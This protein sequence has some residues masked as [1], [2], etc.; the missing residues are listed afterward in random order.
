MTEMHDLRRRLSAA[1]DITEAAS[2]I[3]LAHFNRTLDIIT[4][5][6][7]S[8]VTIADRETEEAIRSR[9]QAEFPQDGIYGEEFGSQGLDKADIWVVDPIDGTRSFI[10]GVPLFGM[11][12]AMTRERQPVLGICRLPAI[13]EVYAAARGLGATRNGAPIHVSRETALDRAMLFINEG[14]KIHAEAPHVFG[15][16]MRAGRLRRLSY[17]CQPHALVASGQVDAV[18]DYDLKPYDYFALAPII[19]EAGGIITDWQGRA[20]TYDSDGRVVTAATPELHAELIAL[21]AETG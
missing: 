7:E 16:L 8:P 1:L 14:E 17:D 2:R 6:D 13:G 12:L 9:L 3:S 19:T 5:D 11:L 10:A 4:K 20:L 15:R 21:L 18:V